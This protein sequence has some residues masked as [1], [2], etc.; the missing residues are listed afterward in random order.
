[1]KRSE[2]YLPLYQAQ[3]NSFVLHFFKYQ[4]NKNNVKHK[5]FP[6]DLAIA[7]RHIFHQTKLMI[8]C[9]TGMLTIY[10]QHTPVHTDKMKRE[11]QA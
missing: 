7:G 1:T 8:R 10:Q 2:F 6:K 9:F 5:H 11:P 4:W 3:Y